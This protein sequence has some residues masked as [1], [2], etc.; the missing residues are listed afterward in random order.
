EREDKRLV[1]MAISTVDGQVA[2]E[3]PAPIHQL[4]KNDRKP[5]G[6]LATPSAATDGKRVVVFFGSSGLLCYDTAGKL[7]WHRKM[8]PFNDRRGATSSPIIADGKVILVEDHET[9]SFLAAFDLQTGKAAWHTERTLFN[10]SYNTPVIWKQGSRQF[11]AVAGSGLVTAYDL[12]TGQPDFFIQGT[13]G[14]ANPTAVIGANDTLF[15]ASANPGPKRE[16][17]PG[18]EDLVAQY[19]KNKDTRLMAAEL[20]GGLFRSMFK[21]FDTDKDGALSAT[22]YAS[23]QEL[24]GTCTNGMIAVKPGGQGFDRTASNLLW[25]VR[26]SIPRTSS[27]IYYQGHLYLVN[28]GGLL[29]CL[30]AKTG[31]SV[32]TVRGSG[33]GKYFGSAVLGDGKIYCASDRGEVTV[34]A[35]DPGLEILSF[36]Q[37]E[38]PIYP[39]PAISGG[40]IY[41]RTETRLFCFGKQE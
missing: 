19:D 17:Q 3:K 34:M 24:M 10:R 35:A 18:F 12:Q 41:L 31:R 1:T 16:F 5:K 33:R 29:A 22:E 6:R 11:V 13:S 37:F 40:R 14:V 39:S 38:E 2:W 28:D 30:D 26:K 23:L 9:G 21:T 7:I 25:H 36:A 4:E 8:G 20:P 27:P 32:K 15:V